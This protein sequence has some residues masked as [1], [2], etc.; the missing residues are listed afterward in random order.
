MAVRLIGNG[1]SVGAVGAGLLL[2]PQAASAMAIETA[3][4]CFTDVSFS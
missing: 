2:P 1:R 4:R 3:K